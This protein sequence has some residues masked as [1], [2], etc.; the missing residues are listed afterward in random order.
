MATPSWSFL[1]SHARALLCLAH[2]PGLRLRDIAARLDV[3]AWCLSSPAAAA[4]Q[5]APS[6]AQAT[7]RMPALA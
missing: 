5:G 2:D 6:G 3:T 7:R 4:G 1:T